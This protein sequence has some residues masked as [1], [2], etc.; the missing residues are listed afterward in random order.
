MILNKILNKQQLIVGW[1]MISSVAL[2][3]LRTIYVLQ[4]NP[5]LYM[6]IYLCWYFF[7][8]IFGLLLIDAL[9]NKKR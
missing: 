3:I 4:L 5:V 1:A 9:R 8:F 7:I 2:V 6:R